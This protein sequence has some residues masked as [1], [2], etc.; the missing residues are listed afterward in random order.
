MST[1]ANTPADVDLNKIE[2][3]VWMRCYEDGLMEIFLG[4]MLLMMGSGSVFMEAYGMSEMGAIILLLVM[5]T[6]AIVLF[7]VGK[8]LV[9]FPR[10]GRV[11]FGPKG[12]ARLKKTTI[13]MSGSAVVGLLV[14]VLATMLHSGSITN[15]NPDLVL[16]LIWVINVVVVFG[17]WARVAGLPRFF[18]IG[19]LFALPL[20][21]LI[22]LKELANVRIGYGAFAVPGLIVVLMGV[23]TL[24]R[25]IRNY[26]P[27]KEGR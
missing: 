6:A 14:F 26:P 3:A 17:L 20:P 13:I 19:F 7:Y 23:V 22:G 9:T 2:R 12:K 5:A 21:L 15:L 16:P 1:N 4:L 18:L 24:A 27:L 25:F 10:I 11:K 8:R